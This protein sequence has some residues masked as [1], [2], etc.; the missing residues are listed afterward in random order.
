MFIGSLSNKILADLNVEFV[1]VDSANAEVVDTHEI[2]RWVLLLLSK[3]T[4]SARGDVHGVQVL[5][6]KAQS[7]DVVNVHLDFQVDLL[8]PVRKE[9]LKEVL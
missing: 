8:V 1:H 2:S 6:S 4:Q 3:K 5:V 9:M 7:I